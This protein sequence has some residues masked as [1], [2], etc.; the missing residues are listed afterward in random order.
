MLPRGLPTQ[1]SASH[2][3]PTLRGCETSVLLTWFCPTLPS[4]PVSV[5]EIN[6][7][8]LFDVYGHGGR[9]GG[10]Q[11]SLGFFGFL[12]PLDMASGPMW[13]GA[14]KHLVVQ[15]WGWQAQGIR[16]GP[17]PPGFCRMKMPI[18]ETAQTVCE[19]FFSEKF[20]EKQEKWP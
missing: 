4:H 19:A 12:L 9:G 20:S 3:V 16:C 1:C 7:H 13:Q 8:L 11:G 14:S 17:R 15:E 10:P 2:K 5:H 18:N 6:S